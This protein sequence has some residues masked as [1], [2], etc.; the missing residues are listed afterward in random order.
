MLRKIAKH[1]TLVAITKLL[2]YDSYPF[3]Y[4]KNFPSLKNVKG[5]QVKTANETTV[6]FS[7]IL[8]VT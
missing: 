7:F 4:K 5:T 6:S 3:I 2:H 8:L 1:R